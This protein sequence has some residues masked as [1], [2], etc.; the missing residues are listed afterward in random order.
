MGSGATGR[1]VKVRTESDEEGQ[2]IDALSSPGV[3]MRWDG[4]WDGVP[5]T[6]RKPNMRPREMHQVGLWH[7]QVSPTSP[8]RS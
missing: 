2:A 5:S 4:G 3:K 1:R 7:G 6:C 8:D